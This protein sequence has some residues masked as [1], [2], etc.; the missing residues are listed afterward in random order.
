MDG[1]IISPFSLLGGT[2]G[3]AMDVSGLS[4]I[5]VSI[6]LVFGRGFR[7]GATITVSVLRREDFLPFRVPPGL[8]SVPSEDTAD[9]STC[10]TDDACTLDGRFVMSFSE[11]GTA[12]FTDFW[13]TD[14]DRETAPFVCSPPPNT[15]E[16]PILSIDSPLRWR[17]LLDDPDP[18]EPVL[19]F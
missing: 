12:S 2:A 3:P 15:F 8:R 14:G 5:G 9:D 16:I 6:P 1:G 18:V 17:P 10:D 19:P 11:D 7:I 4:F 13:L